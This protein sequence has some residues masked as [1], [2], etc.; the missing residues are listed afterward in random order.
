MSQ[1]QRVPDRDFVSTNVRSP[2][3]SAARLWTREGPSPLAVDSIAQA[4]AD[5]LR[6][7]SPA[8]DRTRLDAERIGRL[9]SDAERDL[10]S[11][12]LL[13]RHAVL[14]PMRAERLGKVDAAELDRQERD[15]LA[16]LAPHFERYVRDRAEG[17]RPRLRR[18]SREDLRRILDTPVAVQL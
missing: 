6:K 15:V 11:Q 3:R 13:V 10:L 2:W 4:L 5:V 12:E 18:T 7:G 9:R 14:G 8:L 16:A 17:R 1:V